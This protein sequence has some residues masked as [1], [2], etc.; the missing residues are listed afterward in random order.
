MK[1]Y[2]APMEGIT[3]YVFRQALQECFK[4]PDKC[5]TPFIAPN[6]NSSLKNRE[7]REVLPEHNRGMHVVPQILT[8]KADVFVKTTRELKEMGYNEVN[9]NLGCPSGTVVAKKRGSGLLADLKEL[10][11]FLEG[12]FEKTELPVSI[13]TRLGMAEPEEFYEILEIYNKYPLSELIIHPRVQKEFYKNSPHMD[14]F[15]EAM[16]T[17]RHEICYNGDLFTAEDVRA[18]QKECPQVER[19]MIGRGLVVNP[20]LLNLL[21]SGNVSG[22]AACANGNCMTATTHGQVTKEK[23]RAF[24]DKIF[25]AYGQELYGDKNLLY[26]MKEVWFY[27]IRLFPDSEKEAKKIRKAQHLSEYLEVVDKLF[28]EKELEFVDKLYF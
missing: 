19:I 1:Y 21:E 3:G 24:H 23:I 17:S 4:M 14:I 25:A 15:R 7:K 6:Q 26:K 20:G 13:K 22:S 8:N 27:M 16:R 18:F 2:L 10:D 28:A 12:I 9:L 5:I 11:A